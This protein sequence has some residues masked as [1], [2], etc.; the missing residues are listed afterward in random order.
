[1]FY[2]IEPNTQEPQYNLSYKAMIADHTS[3][4][5]IFTP[6]SGHHIEELVPTFVEIFSYF[7]NPLFTDPLG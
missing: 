7:L 2:N 5:R 6:G 3:K 4:I 1:M